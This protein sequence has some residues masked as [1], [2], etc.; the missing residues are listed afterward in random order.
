VILAEVQTYVTRITA[1]PICT[2]VILRRR[3]GARR[4]AI[5]IGSN[6]SADVRVALEAAARARPRN[7]A[8]EEGDVPVKGK[9]I[10]LTFEITREDDQYVAVCPELDIASQGDTVEDAEKHLDDAVTLYLDVIEED[11]ERERI[12]KERGI[13]AVPWDEPRR[14]DPPRYTSEKRVPLPA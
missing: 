7:L 14:P 6:D 12:F 10:K 5:V 9:M 3:R 1:C 2:G 4:D 11:G 13:Q 8:P